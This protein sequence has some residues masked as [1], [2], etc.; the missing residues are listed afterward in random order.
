MF[1]RYNLNKIENRAILYKIVETDVRFFRHVFEI[2]TTRL[3]V[4]G[5]GKARF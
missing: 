5:A 2:E 1:I 3:F 4:F